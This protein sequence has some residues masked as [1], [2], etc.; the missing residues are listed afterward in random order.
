M[1]FWLNENNENSDVEKYFT[2]QANLWV[3][4][5]QIHQLEMNDF[6]LFDVVQLF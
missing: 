5:T 4:I 1:A 6:Q 2:E 3:L